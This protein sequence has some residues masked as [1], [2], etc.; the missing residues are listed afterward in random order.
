MQISNATK[1]FFP[2]CEIMLLNPCQKINTTADSATV[3]SSSKSTNVINN[4]NEDSTLMII[5]TAASTNP[6][7]RD[8]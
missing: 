7:I 5:Q 1:L 4:N 6:L 8:F 3:A 2:L